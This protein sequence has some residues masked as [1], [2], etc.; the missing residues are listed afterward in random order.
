MAAMFSNV[1]LFYVIFLL[2]SSIGEEQKF[3]M[4]A[5]PSRRSICF[6]L[7]QFYCTIKR[8]TSKSARSLTRPIGV[9]LKLKHNCISI[10][11]SPDITICM[12]VE[13][14]PGPTTSNDHYYYTRISTSQ[15]VLQHNPFYYNS[16]NHRHQNNFHKLPYIEELAKTWLEIG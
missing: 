11:R 13:S 8:Y 3:D 5:Y 10:P 2:V 16:V 1:P 12:D 15:T 4:F 9:W 14:N 6:N 7:S